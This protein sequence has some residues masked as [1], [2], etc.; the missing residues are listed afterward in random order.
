LAYLQ[1]EPQEMDWEQRRK[2]YIDLMKQTPHHYFNFGFNFNDFVLYL[3]KIIWMRTNR[4][5][6]DEAILN[7]DIDLRNKWEDHIRKQE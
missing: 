2:Q 4:K 3:R 6:I 7:Q 1:L 5:V